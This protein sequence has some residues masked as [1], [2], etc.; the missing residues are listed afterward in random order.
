MTSA[1]NIWKWVVPEL[2]GTVKRVFLMKYISIWVIELYG[3]N[4]GKNEKSQT[5]ILSMQL[6]QSTILQA[7]IEL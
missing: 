3:I 4:I 2:E 6:R 5:T 7:Y 1:R